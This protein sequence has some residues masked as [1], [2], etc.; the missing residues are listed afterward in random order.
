MFDAYND[1]DEVSGFESLYAIEDRT[2][3][4]DKNRQEGRRRGLA[5][6][7]RKRGGKISALGSRLLREA[8]VV[9]EARAKR[10]KGQR[11]FL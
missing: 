4:K 2:V 3:L 7:E 1:L 5:G 9:S 11:T 6:V 8:E 10:G